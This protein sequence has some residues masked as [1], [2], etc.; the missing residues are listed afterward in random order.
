MTARH[1]RQ[2]RAEISKSRLLSNLRAL[3]SLQHQGEFLCPMVKC[4]GYGHGA[5]SVSHWLVEDG[6]DALGVALVEEGLELRRGGIANA[7]VLVF[8]VL[9]ET[10]ASCLQDN[11]LTPVVS[12]LEELKFLAKACKG[13]SAFSIHLKIDTGM[14]RLGFE[15]A[16]LPMVRQVLVQNPSLQVTG[17]CTHL[18]C[19]EDMGQ[20]G[21]MSVKQLELFQQ[22]GGQL[23][24]SGVGKH[25]LNSTALVS[26]KFLPDNQKVQWANLGARPG[27]SLY[28]CFDD[29]QSLNAQGQAWVDANLRPVMTLVAELVMTKRLNPGESVSYGATWTAKVP[30]IVGVVGLGYGD[31]Y[32]RRFSNVG[33][34]LCRGNRVPV[35]GRVCM[36]YTLIDLGEFALDS[37]PKPGDEVIFFGDAEKK[38][39]A[40]D[41]AQSA[42]TISYEIFTGISA[43]VPRREV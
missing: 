28:G 36:D 18:A 32:P 12:T 40:L 31:G 16:S 13:R 30:T 1:F 3:K 42:G 21:S 8:G 10:A 14:H 22:V 39:S 19:A 2:T 24:L 35:I 17:I 37:H 15:W 38:I 6:V 26:R 27:I 33:T 43:R 41:L 20:A 34:V 23:G 11:G 29:Y 4:N 5:L 9:P 25:I 7:Q